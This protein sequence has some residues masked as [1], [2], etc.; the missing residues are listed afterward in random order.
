MRP[1][2]YIL[3]ILGILVMGISESAQSLPSD[4]S[5]VV[6]DAQQLAIIGATCSLTHAGK[7][8]ATRITDENGTAT[9]TGLSRGPYDLRVEKEG[10]AIF[11]RPALKPSEELTQIAVMLNVANISAKVSVENPS[12]NPNTIE[13]G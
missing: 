10:F 4:L 7:I 11:E 9:F 1:V 2:E 8:I 6:T 13:S 12:T 3:I 5:L